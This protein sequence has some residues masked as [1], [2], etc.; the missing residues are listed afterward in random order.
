MLPKL[1]YVAL[2]VGVSAQSQQVSCYGDHTLC[3]SELGQSFCSTSGVCLPCYECI[4]TN[5]VSGS[6]GWCGTTLTQEISAAWAASGSSMATVASINPKIVP[7][8]ADEVV[9]DQT[10]VCMYHNEYSRQRRLNNAHRE[11]HQS[12]GKLLRKMGEMLGGGVGARS[13]GNSVL[14]TDLIQGNTFV[15]GR[16]TPA[17]VDELLRNDEV[18]FCTP[19]GEVTDQSMQLNPS[20]WGLDRVDQR[21]MPLDGVYETGTADGSGV[22]IYVVDTGVSKIHAD[23][24]GRLGGGFNAVPTAKGSSAKDDADWG[25]CNGHGTHCAGTAAGTLHGVA[26]KAT[27]Y[28]VRVLG[29]PK[30]AS[31][32]DAQARTKRCSKSGSW[33]SVLTG[34]DWVLS[35]CADRR[36]RGCVMSASIGGGKNQAIN[37]MITRL[38]AGG[39]VPVIAAGNAA[40]DACLESPGSSPDAITVGATDDADKLWRWHSSAGSNWGTCVDILAPG[41]SIRSAWHSTAHGTNAQTGTSMATPH[42]AGAAAVFA[43]EFKAANGGRLPTPDEVKAALLARAT[44]GAVDVGVAPTTPNKLLFTDYAAAPGYY[45]TASN[46]GLQQRRLR[47]DAPGSGR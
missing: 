3:A 22:D 25:D 35:R 29:Q 34:M 27:V 38:K 13:A 7:A 43:A 12:V 10:F 15:S 37:D 23:F 1:F 24:A 45:S 44:V 6:C 20:S 21:A 11:R 26:K 18:A 9:I 31:D 46:L 28:G 42:V 19:D 5:G 14:V 32:S 16:M 8:S 47:G 33:S 40:K 4:R 17:A 36:D 30:G 2:A 41:V 39:V